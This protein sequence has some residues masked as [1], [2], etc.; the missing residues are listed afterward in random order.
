MSVERLARLLF[1]L[2]IDVAPQPTLM[3]L[4]RRDHRM[5]GRLEVFGSMAVLG[6]VAASHVP[7]GEARPQM[8][9]GIAQGNTLR[10]NVHLGRD[11]MAVGE[12]FA[13]WHLDPLALLAVKNVPDLPPSLRPGL[14]SH[15]ML[16]N[17]ML[18]R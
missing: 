4:R 7:T 15:R 10:A 16:S 9:P 18:S 12:V 2:L 3:R 13:E 8:Y 14:G 5:S 1:P 6:R 11:I 17:R